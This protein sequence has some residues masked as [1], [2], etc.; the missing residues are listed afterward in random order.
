MEYAPPYLQGVA[1][2]PGRARGGA[3]QG[4]F[5]KRAGWWEGAIDRLGR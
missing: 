1:N 2:G 3:E 4:W 5:G